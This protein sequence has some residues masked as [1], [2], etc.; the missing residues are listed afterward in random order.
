[1][2]KF[3]VPYTGSNMI[4]TGKVTD[5]TAADNRAYDEK[6]AGVVSTICHSIKKDSRIRLQ[7]S[8]YQASTASH[9]DAASSRAPKAV[10]TES[11]EPSS[12]LTEASGGHYRDYS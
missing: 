2:G 1:M 6:I 7:K 9:N 12:S 10:K 8:W 4:I 11:P 5:R 3:N